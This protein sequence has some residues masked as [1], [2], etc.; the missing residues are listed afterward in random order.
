MALPATRCLQRHADAFTPGHRQRLTGADLT[1]RQ[2]ILDRARHILPAEAQPQQAEAVRRQFVFA[3]PLPAVGNFKGDGRAFD[4]YF[5][6]TR[7]R[8]RR[9]R[10]R[11]RGRQR[12]R[13]GGRR[14]GSWR[15]GNFLRLYPFQPEA[16]QQLLVR[17]QRDGVVQGEVNQPLTVRDEVPLHRHRLAQHGALCLQPA[18]GRRLQLRLSVALL[19]GQQR[20]RFL[21]RQLRRGGDEQGACARSRPQWLRSD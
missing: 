13:G 16:L 3:S 12:C 9:F 2:R 14:C 15:P 20:R 10:R 21:W 6:P 18:N 1:V 7:H 19:T 5:P 17:R 8:L 11:R 4:R